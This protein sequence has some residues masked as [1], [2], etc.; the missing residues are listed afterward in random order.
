MTPHKTSR[1]SAKIGLICNPNRSR[2][3]HEPIDW[4][5]KVLEKLLKATFSAQLINLKFIYK[6]SIEIHVAALVSFGANRNEKVPCGCS[7]CL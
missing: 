3:L 5:E 7:C 1:S 4:Q 6:L 2:S